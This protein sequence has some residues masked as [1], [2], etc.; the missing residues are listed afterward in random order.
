M[1]V[2]ACIVRTI[3]RIADLVVYAAFAGFGL[4]IAGSMLFASLGDG[5]ELVLDI[6]GIAIVLII[7]IRP[8][9]S[10]SRHDTL[11]GHAMCAK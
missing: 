10:A 3:S 7:A 8:P 2:E 5:R 4:F 11:P 9:R 6:S 1:R